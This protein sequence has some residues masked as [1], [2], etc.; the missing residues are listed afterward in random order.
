MPSDWTHLRDTKFA[1]EPPPP[2]WPAGVRPIS[3]NG[4]SLFGIGL[5]NRLYWDGRLVELRR[6]VHLNWWQGF[7]ATIGAFGAFATGVVNVLH[8]FGV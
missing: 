2:D 8:Y 7:L 1:P 3:L 6:T 5:D 4:L